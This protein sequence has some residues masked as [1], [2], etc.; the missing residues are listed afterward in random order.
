MKHTFSEYF[1]R[2]FQYRVSWILISTQQ[3]VS[4]YYIEQFQVKIHWVWLF[5]YINE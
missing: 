4:G 3:R 2:E 5:L 1:I